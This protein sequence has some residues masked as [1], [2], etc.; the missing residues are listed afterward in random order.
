MKTLTATDGTA[1][2]TT[3]IHQSDL[4]TFRSCPEKLRLD[5]VGEYFNPSST[6]A[7]IG[8]C[9]HHF[10]EANLWHR[11][12]SGDYAG[13]SRVV[14]MLNDQAAILTELWP[15]L[16]QHP[17]LVKDLDS[18]VKMLTACCIQWFNEIRSRLSTANTTAWEIEAPFSVEIDRQSVGARRTAM[19]GHIDFFDGEQIWDWKTASP[20]EPWRRQRYDIQSTVYTWAINQKHGT[21]VP[22]NLAFVPRDGKGAQ[23]EQLHRTQGHW[24]MMIQEALTIVR[25]V[26]EMGTT[27]PW[28]LRP[29]DWH[30]SERWCSQN[31]QG[32]CMGAV[33]PIYPNE[34]INLTMLLDDGVE[35]TVHGADLDKMSETGVIL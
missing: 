10:I 7:Q 6:S 17:H 16:H 11:K 8:T 20:R 19:R 28:P 4:S 9:V 13:E 12:V 14:E 34:S 1:W 29:T 30:C 25:M 32:K 27:Q 2:Q 22:F 18:G 33:N 15:T 21:T 26:Q 5:Y 35:R 3:Y 23:I 24:D 31:A